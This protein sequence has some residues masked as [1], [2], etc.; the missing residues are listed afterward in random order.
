MEI[1]LTTG[2][3]RKEKIMENEVDEKAKLRAW[4]YQILA[5]LELAESIEATR[6]KTPGRKVI[7]EI[8]FQS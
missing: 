6:T 1:L 3:I 2:K 5:E 4:L 7:L 8:Q